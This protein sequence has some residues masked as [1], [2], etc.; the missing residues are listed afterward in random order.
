MPP[1]L[2]FPSCRCNLHQFSL[3]R[4]PWFFAFV[5]F[6]ID[7]FHAKNHADCSCNYNSAEFRTRA[8]DFS[9]AEQK[10]RPLADVATSFA[11][12]DQVSFLFMMRFKLACMNMYE[13]EHQAG[14]GRVFWRRAPP[15]HVSQ[16]V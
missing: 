10:N 13:R 7:E 3:N 4:E 2:P 12:M 16:N 5:C 15:H 14:T 8:P 6:L 1:S 11:H 9:L